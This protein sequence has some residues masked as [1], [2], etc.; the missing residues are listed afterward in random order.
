MLCDKFCTYILYIW[1]SIYMIS[2]LPVTLSLA[3][4]GHCPSAVFFSTT[5]FYKLSSFLSSGG[6]DKGSILSDRP[7]WK[8]YSVSLDA[9]HRTQSK[10]KVIILQCTS[11]SCWL[12]FACRR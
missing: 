3:S 1:Y 4:V 9:E 10:S 5:T 11:S 8:C 7:T 12:V 6:K 2:D